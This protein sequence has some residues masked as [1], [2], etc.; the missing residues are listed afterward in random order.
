MISRAELDRVD[1]GDRRYKIINVIIA[2]F[3]EEGY[4]CIKRS[5]MAQMS[6]S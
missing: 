6:D 4:N 1:T 3:M 5:R 2:V